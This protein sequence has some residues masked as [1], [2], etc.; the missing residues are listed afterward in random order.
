VAL[1]YMVVAFLYEVAY[2]IKHLAKAARMVDR[3]QYSVRLV[4]DESE[5]QRVSVVDQLAY[6]EHSVSYE[7]LH[8]LWKAYPR[9]LW[10]IWRGDEVIGAVEIWP[11][12]KREF[13]DMS[14]GRRTEGSLNGASIDQSVKKQYWYVAGIFLVKGKR[15]SDAIRTLVSRCLTDWLASP[16]LAPSIDIC[17][18]A[19]SERGANMLRRFGFQMAVGEQDSVHGARVFVRKTGNVKRLRRKWRMLCHSPALRGRRV[20]TERPEPETQS[21]LVTEGSASA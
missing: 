2:P 9:G 16:D 5:L 21:P 17:A 18:I 11:L 13:I 7:F 10:G 15:C 4:K 8:A 19:A 3:R 6:G 1:V 12:E 20:E 14:A